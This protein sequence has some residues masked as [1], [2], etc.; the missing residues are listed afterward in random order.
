[1]IAWKPTLVFEMDEDAQLSYVFDWSDW[2]EGDA[3][4]LSHLII[5]SDGI[6]VEQS[7]QDVDNTKVSVLLHSAQGTS[8]VTCRITTDE[9][10]PQ[11]DDRSITIKAVNK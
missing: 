8:T 1:M 4:I 7:A 2:L 9:T 5:A 3:V 10:P 11:I 6:E